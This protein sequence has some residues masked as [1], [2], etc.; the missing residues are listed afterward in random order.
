[1]PRVVKATVSDALLTIATSSLCLVLNHCHLG[2]ALGHVAS[3]ETEAVDNFIHDCRSQW[4][5]DQ[6]KCE[7]GTSTTKPSEVQLCRLVYI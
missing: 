7:F 5:R 2:M 4:P 6:P 1:M 3:N